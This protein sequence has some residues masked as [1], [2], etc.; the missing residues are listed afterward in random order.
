V[1]YKKCCYGQSLVTKES[2]KLKGTPPMQVG[3]YHS[4]VVKMYKKFLENHIE[5][6]D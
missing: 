6:K 4:R 3:G 1:K 2:V 5:N